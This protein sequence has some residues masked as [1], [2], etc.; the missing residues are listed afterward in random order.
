[1]TQVTQEA[2]LETVVVAERCDQCS[3]RAMVKVIF[4]YGNL[5]FCLH[6]YN[7]NAQALTER[8]AIAKLLEVSTD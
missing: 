1:M 2:I 6:H 4:S 7:K 5:W 8:G 3:A